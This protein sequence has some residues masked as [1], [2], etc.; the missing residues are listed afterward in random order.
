MV[1]LYL[2]TVRYGLHAWRREFHTKSMPRPEH[3]KDA[4]TW[5]P[6]NDVDFLSSSSTPTNDLAQPREHN[7]RPPVLEANSLSPSPARS[8]SPA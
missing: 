8:P 2:K 7:A 3:I 6:P 5:A 4:S 1:C